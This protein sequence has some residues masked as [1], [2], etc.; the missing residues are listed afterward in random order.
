MTLAATLLLPAALALDRLLGEAPA[1]IHPVCL[2]GALASRL[3]ALL[4][5]GPNSRRMFWAGVAAGT[6]VV[7]PAA[8]AAA[9]LVLLAERY[10]G[11][12]GGWGAAAFAVYICLAPRCLQ[13][14]ALRVA[15]HLEQKD[16]GAARE[17]LGWIVGRQTAELDAH[18]VA[19]ACVESV[20]ENL[21]DAVLSTLF[22]AGIGLVLLGYPGAAALALAHRACNMLDAM[23]GRKNDRYI[24]FGTFAARMDDALNCIPA[25]LALPCIALAARFSPELLPAE[26]LRVGW[27]DRHGHE[28]PNSAWSEAPFAGALG[29]KLGGPAIYGGMTAQHPWIGEGTPDAT[30]GHIRLAVRLMWHA[31]LTF[32]AFAVLALGAVSLIG[33]SG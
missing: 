1:R 11:A 17:A 5:R 8:G 21:T 29:L 16:L 24:R 33:A 12:P 4:R 10:G 20:A 3:E 30:A 27:Q 22:W 25:R 31:A 9:A 26:S 32:A 14:S 15:G 23:W 6:L 7:L 18:G 28:S 19:R 2:M 13:E